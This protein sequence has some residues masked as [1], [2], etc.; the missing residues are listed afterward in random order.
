MSWDCP[1]CGSN[2][3]CWSPEVY[4]LNRREIQRDVVLESCAQGLVNA[5]AALAE[6]ANWG[7]PS[8]KMTYFEASPTANAECAKR[9]KDLNDYVRLTKIT[10]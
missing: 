10:L 3:S 9:W 6:P 8:L 7:V 2:R 5:L 4:G 1:T